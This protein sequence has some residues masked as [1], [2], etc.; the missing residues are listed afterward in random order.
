MFRRFTSAQDA[1]KAQADD[2]KCSERARKWGMSDSAKKW[3]DSADHAM[4]EFLRITEEEHNAER[5]GQGR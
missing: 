4:G 1:L 2:L 5:N 3:Q